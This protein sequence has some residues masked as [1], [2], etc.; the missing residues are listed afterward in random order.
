MAFVPGVRLRAGPRV[1]SRRRLRPVTGPCWK[2]ASTLPSRP[3]FR[4]RRPPHWSA[5]RLSCGNKGWPK[6][7][8]RGL[9]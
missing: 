2:S 1:S 8:A 7:R 9:S 3:A 4:S 6:F 5:T